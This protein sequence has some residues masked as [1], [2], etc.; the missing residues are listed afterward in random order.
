[1]YNDKGDAQTNEIKMTGGF[2]KE[3]MRAKQAG[4]KMKKI[5]I[6]GIPLMEPSRIVA[7]YHK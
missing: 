2:T 5:I 4:S 1:M 3:E 7:T 6:Y